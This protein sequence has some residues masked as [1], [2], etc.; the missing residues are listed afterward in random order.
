MATEP[1]GPKLRHKMAR[2]KISLDSRDPVYV[3]EISDLLQ[4][5]RYR[6]FDT[7]SAYFEFSPCRHLV[8]HVPLEIK[9]T[10]LDYVHYSDVR[11]F[12][13]AFQWQGPN[14]YGRLRFPRDIVYEVNG[15]TC[16]TPD[17]CSLCIDAGNMIEKC[18]GGIRTRMR[19]LDM[20]KEQKCSMTRPWRKQRRSAVD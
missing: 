9:W 18:P 20:L 14:R 1:A 5:L 4:L 7:S 2:S 19:I 12:L 17:W 8:F 16:G 6:A 10:I 15:N 3:P 13:S 11:N